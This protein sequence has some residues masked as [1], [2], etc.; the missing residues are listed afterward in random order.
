M[1]RID[2]DN[3]ITSYDKVIHEI[4]VHRQLIESNLEKNKKIIRDAIRKLPD[5]EIKWQKVQADVY[6]PRMAEAELI[7]GV[8]AFFNLCKEHNVKSCIISHKTEFANYDTMGINLRSAALEW[9]TMKGFFEQD[10]LGLSVGDVYFGSTRQQK[11]NRIRQLKCT[12]F[13]DDLEETFL[14][15]SF[16]IDVEKILYASHG[17]HSS[18]PSMS[19]FTVWEDINNYFFN[20][21]S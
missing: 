5:G 13:I 8:Q 11:I 14:E 7:E 17:Q 19:V 21:K 3:T 6:G 1:R 12:H 16:P 20:T 18:L 2:F 9:M 4:A 10:G 15:D